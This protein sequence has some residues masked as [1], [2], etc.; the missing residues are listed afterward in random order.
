MNNN[1]VVKIVRVM[2][3]KIDCAGIHVLACLANVDVKNWHFMTQWFWLEPVIHSCLSMF[4][5]NMAIV[6]SWRSS[7][8]HTSRK[9]LGSIYFIETKKTFYYGKY[10]QVLCIHEQV[11]RT[12]MFCYCCLCSCLDVMISAFI[13]LIFSVSHSS[14]W[15]VSD[16]W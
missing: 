8:L 12:C 5:L 9:I 15:R 11:D 2:N 7:V 16:I 4:W 13:D 10:L 3:G 14:V 1:T 6:N